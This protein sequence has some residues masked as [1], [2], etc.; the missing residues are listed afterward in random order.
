MSAV[1]SL[2]FAPGLAAEATFD[3]SIAAQ[4]LASALVRYG[5]VAGKEAL[6]K[7]GLVD[8]RVSGGVEGRLTPRAALHQLLVRTG[9]AER[10]VTEGI[11]IA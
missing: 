4:P 1:A 3:F 5:D 6:Y 11:F 9:L 8:G 7:G 10:F 2:A